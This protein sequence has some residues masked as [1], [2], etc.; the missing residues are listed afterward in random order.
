MNEGSV[1]THW[2]FLV[3]PLALGAVALARLGC[4]VLF[5]RRTARRVP[6]PPGRPLVLGVVAVIALRTLSPAPGAA[7]SELS[8]RRGVAAG[9]RLEGVTAGLLLRVGLVA[10]VAAPEV[11]VVAVV[12]SDGFAGV[13]AVAVDEGSSSSLNTLPATSHVNTK[14]TCHATS[15]AAI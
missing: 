4:G 10:E 7:W 11:E 12:V 1:A 6:A 2:H 3:G 15:H 8:G 5:G 9:G 14:D 13:V